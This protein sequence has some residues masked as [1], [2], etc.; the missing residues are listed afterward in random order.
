MRIVRQESEM[1]K[2]FTLAS[3]EARRHSMTPAFSSRIYRNPKHIEFQI[4]GDTHGNIITSG[5]G[6]VLYNA[7]TRSS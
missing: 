1:E 6:N 3:R 4:L 7:S 2:M 5:R